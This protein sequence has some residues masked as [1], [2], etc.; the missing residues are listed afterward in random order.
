MY[1][2]E[3][4]KQILDGS[5]FCS[6]CGAS[7]MKTETKDSASEK[8]KPQM[9]VASVVGK[10][11]EDGKDVKLIEVVCPYCGSKKVT[12][13]VDSPIFGS[14][15]MALG[16][17]LLLYARSGRYPSTILTLCAVGIIGYAFF[18]RS[19][20]KAIVKKQDKDRSYFDCDVCKKQFSIPT[21]AA[22]EIIVNNSENSDDKK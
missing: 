14:M 9:P 16:F 12:Q 4:G 15:G 17:L 13:R 2:H 11:S 10:K 7:L 3:C 1:C 22:D 8:E 19:E 6:N 20:A 18:C 5:K 21:P